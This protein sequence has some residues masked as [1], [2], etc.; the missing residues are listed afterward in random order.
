VTFADFYDRM[1]TAGVTIGIDV[2]AS[3]PAVLLTGG[4]RSIRVAARR[5]F[6]AAAVEIVLSGR[7]REALGA[8]DAHGRGWHV[9][10]RWPE[11]VELWTLD[12]LT[13]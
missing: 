3:G 6:D 2:D 9:R 11:F 10:G 4:S 8:S 7:L 13:A 12:E 1:T 5:G